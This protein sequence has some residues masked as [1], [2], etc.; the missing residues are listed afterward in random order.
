MRRAIKIELSIVERSKLEHNVRSR[1]TP[2]RLGERSKIVLLANEGK[3]NQQIAKQLGKTEHTVGRLRKR[4]AQQG[5]SGIEKELPRGENHGGKNT[6]EQAILR[7]KI[8]EMTTKQK[9]DNATH[10]STRSLADEL[11][12][13]HNFVARVWRSC[14]FKPHLIRT[15]KVSNDPHFEE[16][17]T[18]VVGLYLDP[19]D[20]AV[21]FSVDEKS[22]IQA[23]DRTQP[24]LPI[25]KGRCGTMTHDYKR[26]G[27]STLF[28][29][30]DVFSGKV[31]AKCTKRHRHTEFL[32]FL[33]KVYKETPKD[34]DLHIIVDNYSTHKHKKVN[35]WL[36]KKP[37]VHLHFIPTSSSWLNLVERFFALITEKQLRRGV[38]RSVEQLENTIYTFIEKRN[39]KPKPFVWTKSVDEI[40]TK[41]NRA[42]QSLLNV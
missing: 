12:T 11:E 28:A 39:Q 3:T 4:F 41:V 32:G 33:K 5:L 34:I 27:T 17:L 26:N 31:I 21:V 1:K 22:S 16:K 20:N 24:S 35:A 2:V 13:S 37:R 8:I 29:A 36:A 6:Q 10:W 9:P 40:M 23:L 42:R 7:A 25:V 38:F 19:P 15:F 30:L 18:D 14:G